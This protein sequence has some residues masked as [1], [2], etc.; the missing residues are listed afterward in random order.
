MTDDRR[1]LAAARGRITKLKNLVADLKLEI[2][3]LLSDRDQVVFWR[4][5]VEDSEK[6]IAA[7]KKRILHPDYH[8]TELVK[9]RSKQSTMSLS[10]GG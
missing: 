2:D 10:V 1:K 5:A 7:M 3:E 9:E 8:F 6:T 4:D